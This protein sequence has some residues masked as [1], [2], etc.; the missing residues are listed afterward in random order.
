VE[1]DATW[2][3]CHDGRTGVQEFRS[4]ALTEIPPDLLWHGASSN[5]RGRVP[6]NLMRRG[7]LATTVV[8]EF[9]SDA[10]KKLLLIS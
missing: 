5:P 7:R 4:N 6:W 10:L 1:L 8:Q 3:A 9:R 2:Q